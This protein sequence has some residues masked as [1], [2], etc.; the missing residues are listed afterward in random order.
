MYFKI[1]FIP[2][3]AQLNLCSSRNI[4]Y[5]FQF[6]NSWIFNR[7]IF[8]VFFDEFKV[9]LK[10]FWNIIIVFTVTF[11]QSNVSLLNKSFHFL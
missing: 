10:F 8:S 6:W 9:H 1:R 7:V 3:I 2:V 11:G 4:S 5:Y